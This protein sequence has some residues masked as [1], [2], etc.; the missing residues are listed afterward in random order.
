MSH[1]FRP[2]AAAEYLGAIRFY[3]AR[4]R[5]LGAALIADFEHAVALAVERPLAWR[6]VHPTG[7]RRLGLARFPYSVFYQPLAE[8]IEI[9][10]FAHH[11]QRPQYWLAR[12]E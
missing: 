2:E 7:I 3:E 10:A 8:G 6:Q 4:R 9:T 12:W 11:R 1:R 5:G